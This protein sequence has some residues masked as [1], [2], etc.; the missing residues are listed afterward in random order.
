MMSYRK[1]LFLLLALW[2]IVGAVK[3]DPQYVDII[4]RFTYCWG[5]SF[6]RNADGS[7]TY[8]GKQWGGLAAGFDGADWTEYS[9]L[10]FELSEPSPCA[11][12]PI[13][14]YDGYDEADRHYMNAGTQVAYID[15]DEVKS[16]RVN[17]VALQTAVEATIVVKR[18]YLVKKELPDYGEQPGQLRINELMQSNIDC[19]MDDLNEFPDSWVELYNSGETP[20]NLARYKLGLTADAGSAWQLPTKHIEAGQ[21]VVVYCDKEAQALH[22]DFRLDSGKGGSVYLFF[23]N[24]VDD[25]RTDIEKQPAPNISLGY[26][27]LTDNEWGYQYQPTPG[28]ANCGKI[29]KK[30]NLLGEPVFS[31]NGKVFTTGTTLQLELSALSGSPD[32]TVVRYTLDGSEPTPESP[33]YTSPI[34][35]SQTTTVRAKAFLD[36]YLSS[37]SAT[38]SY[39]FLG[40][41]MTLPVISLVTDDSYWYD[42]RIGILANNTGD[43]KYDWRRPVNIEFFDAPNTESKINQLCE[44][45]V[46]GGATR[47]NPLKSL[48]VY[49][50]KRF[51]TKRFTYEFFP[52][53]RPGVT[54]FKS[55][56]LRNTG[57][58]YYDLYMRDAIIQRTM[59]QHVDLDW[60]AWRPAIVFKN[61]VYKGMLNIRE[62]SNE[63]NIFTH[64][65]DAEG[66]GLEDIDLIENWY[67]LKEG[68]WE[69]YNA[70][71]AFYS[72]HNHT[73]AEYAQW[74][75]WEEFFNLMIM[76]LYFDN[77][78]F[79]GNN[80][81]M[82]RPR[83][84]EGKWRWIAKDTDFGLGLYGVQ[85]DYNTIA[86]LHNPDYD[87]DRAWANGW[88]HT[89]LFR[90]MMEDAD[91]KREFLDRSAIYMG[92]FLNERGTRAIWDPMVEMIKDEYPY[93][94]QAGNGWR[95]WNDYQG[96]LQQARQWLAGRTAHFYQQLAD[97]YEWGT[98]TP[99]TVNQELEADQ[100]IGMTV[101]MNNIKLS[102]PLF[103]GK[104]YAGKQVTLK[105]EGGQLP[106]VGWAF[107]RKN[108]DNTTDEYTISV[109]EYAFEMP[110]CKSLTVNA[111]FGTTGIG[112]LTPDSPSLEDK[113]SWYDLS[114]R[115]LT[116]K[117]LHSGLY[118]H[119]GR[120]VVVK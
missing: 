84:A 40:R 36:G 22:T 85:P 70:F 52:D 19:I 105:A 104:F 65:Q 78:D 94:H 119:N 64:Y 63:D 46:Q 67:E 97:F 99:L 86:W 68:D 34:T 92:D 55:L 74:M 14:F 117:P 62:R 116:G 51:G 24:E 33:E 56:V 38:Q 113:G 80:I 107:V 15:L 3:A 83:T 5:D 48:A 12:Q 60:Q 73:L 91:L 49:A 100:L 1:H 4:D 47:S 77:K 29:C 28:A 71:Q 76:N 58:D 115:R 112:S 30:K 39:I 21:Y 11:V 110:V 118:I 26:K 8:Y 69:N 72:E 53:Q 31:E 96:E 61:G 7:I 43:Q 44:T 18:I 75:D 59:A 10:V 13:I 106:I 32:G 79:P 93:H 103:D 81:V 27:S 23:D 101:S 6:E 16:Q 35:I 120:R 88:D 25:K 89:R 9:Q 109:P 66:D 2:S 41:D 42:A 114:G 87:A 20:V 98:P 90:R 111:V 102:Q 37:R 54:E 17:Q 82:W 50:N 108:N 95:N 57:N 45:R